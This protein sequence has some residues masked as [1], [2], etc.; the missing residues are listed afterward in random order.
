[1]GEGPLWGGRFEQAPDEF[2]AEFNASLRFDRRLV[3][4]DIQG[5]MAY[6]KALQGVGVLTNDELASLDG[7]LGQLASRLAAD[8]TELERAVA[9]GVEDVH[10]FVEAA[11]TAMVGDVAKKLH[12]GRSRNDQVA[13]DFRLYLRDEIRLTQDL[14]KDLQWSF[15]HQAEHNPDA[16]IPGYTHLQRAQPVLWSHYLL[17]FFE[18]FERDR[19]RLDDCYKR[20]NR[21]PLGSG[22][23]AGNSQ[24]VDRQKL[25]ELLGFD[26]ITRNSLDATSDRDF[27]IEFLA[28]ASVVMMHLS[29]LAE[30]L[31]L[32]CTDEF[33]FVTMS[34]QVSTG[35]SL[36]PQKKN[37]DALELIRGKTG[38]VYGNLM[39]ILTVL[40]GLPSCYNKDL[41]EDKEGLFDT[42]DTLKGSLRVMKLVVDTL[43]LNEQVTQQSC[44]NG[45]LNATELADYFV[46]K[47]IPFRTAHHLVGEIVLYAAK[48]NKTLNQLSLDEFRSFHADV[49]E[50]V[51][52]ALSL[53]ATLGSKASVG[54]TAPEQVRDAL[55][56]AKASLQA[57]G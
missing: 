56:A 24:N 38:R 2:F 31:I 37:P 35:S 25:A 3:F 12:T 10:S 39:G 4:A 41:Q 6:A 50:G 54:G 15:V 51:F 55:A 44:E 20:V 29:R 28:A 53:S 22:A 16:V 19:E 17:S 5:S 9:N 48:Q 30:D 27:V 11:L 13:T 49:D 7:A 40:K 46:A 45:F 21:L 33:K 47:Q 42:L 18:M 57:D 23:L 52:A 8:S 26:S 36:M 32:Y 14:L 34:D 43:Q 1:M